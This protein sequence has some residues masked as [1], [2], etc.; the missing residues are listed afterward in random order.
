MVW[1]LFP[2]KDYFSWEKARSHRVSNLGCMGAESPGWFDVSPKNSTQ[3]M[4]HEQAQGCDEAAN[5]QL[6]KA[7][8]FWIMGIISA[9]E[10]SS[11]MQNLM[12]VH[13]FI[14]SV[15]LNVRA[16]QYTRSLSCVYCP[17]W[18]VQWSRHC[19]RMCIPVHSP[20]LPG[21]NDVTQT[22]L[23]MLTVAG[24]FRTNLTHIRYSCGRIF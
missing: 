18:L 2:F 21:Y 16:T 10:C 3:D 19:S 5:H 24:L 15:I 20:W 14:C 12:Q 8:A 13:C 1:N 11:L 23:V 7:V 9:E 6:P 4:M 17:H 22:V